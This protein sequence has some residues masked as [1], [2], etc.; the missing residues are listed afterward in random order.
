MAFLLVLKLRDKATTCEE[1][2]YAAEDC[3]GWLSK[4]CQVATVQG[5]FVSL[6]LSHSH[7]LTPSP[8]HYITTSHY[9]TISLPHSLTL[10]HSH[11]I[12]VTHSLSLT[13]SDPTNSHSHSHSHPHSHSH[14]FSLSLHLNSRS[15][16]EA[17]RL[18]LVRSSCGFG[19][20]GLCATG[21]G[22]TQTFWQFAV[23]F[24]LGFPLHKF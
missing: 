4:T 5:C 24:S 22:G 12:I 11:S 10:T 15:H 13:H 20:G 19:V 16:W 8:S 7:T 2:P 17:H 21:T 14:S 9:L 6:S 1:W 3:F 18:R 23:L